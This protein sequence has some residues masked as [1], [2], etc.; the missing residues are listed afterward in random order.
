MLCF[1]SYDIE[2]VRHTMLPVTPWNL[3]SWDFHWQ[4]RISDFKGNDSAG[5]LYVWSFL[6]LKSPSCC[7]PVAYVV[8][9]S[10]CYTDIS[11]LWCGLNAKLNIL[12]HDMYWC[13][14]ENLASSLR[15]GH[16]CSN[17]YEITF[18]TYRVFQLFFAELDSLVFWHAWRPEMEH[19]IEQQERKQL[20]QLPCHRNP[21]QG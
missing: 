1:I 15:D 7:F 12:F 5:I 18:M 21:F 16:F 2:N 13:F 14:A 4:Y 17:K 20:C 19:Q 11:A 3:Y 10:M 6:S 9:Y 8:H